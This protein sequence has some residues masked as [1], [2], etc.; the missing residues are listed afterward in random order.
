MEKRLVQDG[1]VRNVFDKVKTVVKKDWDMVFI[2]DGMEGAGKSVFAQQCAKYV[3]DT[4]TI[5]RICFTPE[6]FIKA[7]NSSSKHQAIIYDEAYGGMSSRAAM[8]EVNK[9]LMG[10]LAEIRQKNLFVFLILP[11]FFELDKYAAI[12]RSRGLFH[13]YTKD[14]ERGYVAFFNYERK[15]TLYV[16]GKKFYNYNK[17]KSN[18]RARFNKGYHVDEEA[19]RQKKL[20]ALKKREKKEVKEVKSRYATAFLDLLPRVKYYCRT[21]SDELAK[22]TGYSKRRINEL[23]AENPVRN[24]EVRGDEEMKDE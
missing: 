22:W 5:D 4:L 8:S 16:F 7:I 6:E 1:Y 23:I 18:F 24:Q 20:D 21:T 12:H 15:K 2:V 11:S 10:V 9:M 13:V 17:P 19:Y 14:W 3:D